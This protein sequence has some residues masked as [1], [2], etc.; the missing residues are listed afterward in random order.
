MSTR[1][2]S[3][4][5]A[6]FRHRSGVPREFENAMFRDKNGKAIPN[7]KIVEEVRQGYEYFWSKRPAN[8]RPNNKSFR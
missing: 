6:K 3:K 8:A 5:S 7:R 4:N 1:Q 2:G